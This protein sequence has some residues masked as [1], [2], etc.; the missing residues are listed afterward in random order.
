MT[1]ELPGGQLGVE[2]DDDWRV[3]MT[4]PAEEIY[5]GDLSREFLEHLS[6]RRFSRRV[7]SLPPYL[8][9]EI[10]R[11]VAAR[12]AAGVD[13]IS[14]GI[15][16]PDSPTPAHIVAAM[17]EAVHDPATTSIRATRA[18]SSSARRWPAY[19]ERRFGVELDPEAEVMPLLGAKEGLAHICPALLD[20]SD[21]CLAADPG[22]PVYIDRPA[23]RRRPC[24][25]PAAASRAR[26][27]A[28]PGGRRPAVAGQGQDDVRRLSQQPDRRRHRGRLLRPAGRVRQA[29]DMLVV[30]DNAY[31]DI[32]FDGYVAPELPGDARGE[33]RR[34]RVLLALQELQHDRLALGR[35][36]RQPRIVEAF[37]RLKTNIDSGMFT[38][39]QHACDGG[40][41]GPQDCVADMRRPVPAVG[42]TCSSRHCAPSASRRQPPKGTIYLW[43]PVP[44]GHTSASFADSMLEQADVIVSPGA[45]Y[46]PSGE[47]YVRFC[48][49]VPDD[50][51]EEAVRRIEDRAKL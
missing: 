18:R 22:Y 28:R 38:A 27:P 23:A 36:R 1:V 16:D 49:T 47:G 20:E 19:Y 37:W 17:A 14:L 30:H 8:F 15:G 4:G 44:E 31:A 46:G 43:V 7:Q 2:V 5:H 50:R 32:T 45:A 41:S 25:A 51:L 9:A 39:V 35:H 42:A 10:E 11:K 21:V 12:R 6:M 33:G 48:S 24:R 26:V 29:H 34:R 40:A 13:I 3:L